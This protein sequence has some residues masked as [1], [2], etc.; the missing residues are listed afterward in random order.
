[1]GRLDGKVAIVT[2]AAQG[3]GAVQARRLAGEGAKVVLTDVT[4]DGARIADEIG[5]GALFIEHDV[6]DK[7]AWDNVI[8]RAS[9]AFGH[10]HVLVNN[11]GIYRP[12]PLQQTDEALLDAHYAVNVKGVFLGM[13]SVRDAM[14]AAGGGSIINTS[15]AAGL[16]AYPNML[17]YGTSKWAVRGLTKYAAA[18][19]AQHGIRVNSIHPGLIDT[20]MIAANGE[21]T[22]KALATMIPLG[23]LGTS[24]DIAD[25]VVF[26]AS[27]ESSYMT[28]AE[29]AID[30]G[31]A[32]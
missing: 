11:A 21:E 27:D 10:I 14:I 29:I 5:P 13:A 17:A 8:I 31:N 32:M 2:G 30:G 28:G 18:D 3:Q 20:P 25:L 9:H 19:L 15:S 1:M 7:D 23:R 12:A 6:A 22:N 16:R 24:A 4:M 26:L